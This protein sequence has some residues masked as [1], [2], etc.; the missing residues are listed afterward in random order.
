VA[1]SAYLLVLQPDSKLLHCD[2]ATRANL[3]DLQHVMG[4]LICDML[5]TSA[6][7]SALQHDSELLNCDVATSNNLSD[8]QHDSE[9][10]ICDMC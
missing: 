10:L 9:L 4:Q 7:L 3:S 2:V 8:I 1:N 5:T 6:Y